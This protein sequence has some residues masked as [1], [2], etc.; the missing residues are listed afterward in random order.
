MKP[1]PHNVTH[2]RT[3]LRRYN[4]DPKKSLGQ[5]FLFDDNLLAQIAATA[6]LEP[7]DNVLE[8]G[9]GVGALTHHLAQRAGQVL[10]IEL[11]DRLLPILEAELAGYDNIT[12]IHGDILAQD[13]A[14]W[15]GGEPY[16]VVAN[17][18]YYITGAILRH[19]LDGHLLD[20]PHRPS[21][22]V[23]TVQQEVAARLT[24]VP[25]NMSLLA[26]SVQFYGRVT[27]AN[28][29]KAGAFWPRPDVDSAVIRI[30]VGDGVAEQV[31]DEKKFFR[32][33][34]A[35]FSQKRKQLQKNLRSLGY[36]RRQIQ[37]ALDQA[38]IDPQRRAETLS[39][40]EWVAV[41]N[42]L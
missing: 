5:N 25:P 20:A 36:E 1:E 39:L 21:L 32:L 9:P 42:A 22:V 14:A 23:M 7:A 12:L 24:A 18:P 40:E 16:K 28:T 13:P 17:V 29:I 8:I 6:D 10:A 4:L 11:D 35:G 38:G 27:I 2:P 3:L 26:V 19:L 30:K 15:F 33:V 31:A 37:A 41:Y 34:K